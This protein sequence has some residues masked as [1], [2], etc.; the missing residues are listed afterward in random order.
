VARRLS[1]RLRELAVNPLDP[2]LARQMETDQNRPFSRVGDWRVVLQVIGEQKVIEVSTIQHR[3]LGL[4]SIAVR[5][6][7][8]AMGRFRCDI[9]IV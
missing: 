7:A 4:P 9:L 8:L 6:L 5:P 2:R 3:S 1:D